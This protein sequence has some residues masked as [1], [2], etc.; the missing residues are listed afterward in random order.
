MSIKPEAD[1]YFSGSD[2]ERY[3]ASQLDEAFDI[4]YRRLHGEL[5]FWFAEPKPHTRER[6]GLQQEVLI[7][8]SR[9]HKT[10]ARVLTA[11]ESIIQLREFKYR[12]EKVVFIL[13]HNGSIEETEELVRASEERIII[14]ILENEL[15]NPNKG[16]LFIRTKLVETI[17]A[18]NLFGMNSPI[19]SDKYFF[20]RSEFVQSLVNRTTVSRE[21]SGVFGLRKTG[22]TSV[23]RAIQ[24]RLLGRPL[25]TE[26]IEC[27]NPGIHATR[28]WEVL[29]I[30]IQRCSDTLKRDFNRIVQLKGDYNSSNAGSRFCSDIKNIIEIGKLDQMLLMFDEIEFIT[31]GL[32]GALGQ[33]WDIDFVP[34][35]QTIRSTHQETQGK[36]VFL[37]AGVNPTCVESSH[38]SGIQNPIFQLTAPHYLEPFTVTQTRDMVRT[39]GKYTGLKF[40]ESVYQYLQETYGGHPFLIRI[41][42]SEVWKASDRTDPNERQTITRNSFKNCNLTIQSRM[43]PPIKDILLSLVWWYPDEYD[44]L[45]ILASGDSAFVADYLKKEPGSIFQFAQYGILKKDYPDQFAIADVRNFLNQHGEKYRKQISPFTR[46]DM[47]PELLP[48]VPDLHEIGKLFDMR[49][50]TEMMLRRI[51]I[52]FFQVAYVFDTNKISQAMIKSLPKRQDRGDVKDL[53]VGRLPQDVV[54]QLFCPDLKMLIS[55]NWDMFNMLFDNNKVRFEMNMDTLNIARRIDAHTKPITQSEVSEFTNS[56]NWLLTRLSKIPNQLN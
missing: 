5:T 31:C 17:G 43:E 41:A 13:I 32:S 49:S 52:L 15:L 23:F 18:T 9:H 34:F 44:L 12:V 38:F 53:F 20:G 11:I 40:D 50:K 16:S 30:L 6:F 8:Y 45:R 28:W 10:D 51:I 14:P 54:N 4:T 25:L 42:C 7:I 2:H 46:G 27:S 36:L 37:V 21:N 1:A 26:Y 35:W 33:H 29:E 3:I 55:N 24:R 48:E 39:I 19:T 56:Y 22:K 47:P